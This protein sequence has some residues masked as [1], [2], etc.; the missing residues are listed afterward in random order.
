MAQM[1]PLI[2]AAVLVP[3]ATWMREQG[4]PAPE[5]LRAEG[6]NP[7]L[8]DAPDRPMALRAA[9]RLLVG[10]SRSAGSDIGLSIIADSSLRELS[11]LGRIPIT[12][13]TPREA[14]ARIARAM[15]HHSSHEQV[16][17]EPRPGGAVL[18][19]LF[20]LRFDP[21]TLHVCQVYAAAV[22][23]AVLGC[24]AHA[25]PRFR[26]VAIAPHPDDGLLALQARLDAPVSASRTRALE[27]DISDAAL[28]APY[29]RE[30]REGPAELSPADWPVIRGDATLS[31]SLRA[32][33][34]DLVAI[35]ETRVE[36]IADLAGT[37]SRTLQRRLTGEGQS[38]KAL[39]DATRRDLALARIAGSAAPIGSIAG[40]VGYLAHSSLTRAVRRWTEAPPRRIRDFDYDR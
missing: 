2:R 15:G 10:L 34:P 22:A 23:R 18:R 14:F 30:G 17:F 4:L 20:T 6:I 31:G 35:G 27:L 40:E 36:V 28:D 1:V 9:A 8:I 33:L 19:H 38:V 32:I 39:V 37:S 26:A 3:I 24:T 29:L 25:G 5:L 13:R 12:A 7:A 21:A 16:A 11:N